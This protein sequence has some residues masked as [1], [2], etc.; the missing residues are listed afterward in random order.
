MEL[1]ETQEFYVCDGDELLDG[2]CIKLPLKFRGKKDS[3]LIIRDRGEVR[4]F[5]NL[6]VHMPRTLD[7]ESH[8]VFDF[9]KQQ[10][11]CSMHGI[12]YSSET[13]ESLSEICRGKKL[14]SIRIIEQDNKIL[15]RD[16][17][18]ARL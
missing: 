2:D 15:I 12:V 8:S 16:K 4:A 14:T 1:L 17:R 18:V 13:G 3:A 5:H 11:R 10:L 9:E 6:C 7:C